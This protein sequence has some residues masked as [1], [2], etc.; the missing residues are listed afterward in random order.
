MQSEG[1]LLLRRNDIANLL[2]LKDCINAV[3]KIFR[4]QGEGKVPASGILGVKAARGGLHVKAGLLPADKSYVVSKLNKNFPGNR[5]T[6]A[7]PTIQGLIVV[8]DSE[9]GAP[10]AVL[11]SIE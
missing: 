1:T 7:L 3:E 6:F 8:Y 9:N 4:W 11:D 10:L 5:A 2:S